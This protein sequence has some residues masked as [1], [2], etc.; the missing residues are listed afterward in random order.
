MGRVYL[1]ATRAGRPV[2]VKVVRESYAQDLDF[3]RRFRVEAEAAMKV[4]GAFT[5]PVLAAD[6]DA[7]L[8]WLAT[9]Y[10][11]APSLSEVVATHGPMPP[12]T[13]RALAAGLVE[14]LTAVH[15]AG[16]VHRDLKP[17]NILLAEDG[18][19]LI[20]FGLARALDAA[21]LTGTGQILG[22]AGY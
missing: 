5:A 19:R 17:S 6:P 9:A 14:A 20:D 10:L 15:A 8:P 22:T 7:P 13:V 11:P 3:R 18:P 12:E 2:A 16:L 4:G 21:S 1:A